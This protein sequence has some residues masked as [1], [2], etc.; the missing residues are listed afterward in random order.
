MAIRLLRLMMTSLS[1]NKDY[2]LVHH[3]EHPDAWA[4]RFESGDFVE[5]TIVFGAIAYNDKEE[6]L[7]FDFQIVD[8]PDENLSVEN[9]GLQNFA[10]MVLL[11]IIDKGLEEGF[12]KAY[13]RENG[14]ELTN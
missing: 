6:A 7:T 10:G 3:E 11:D 13:D 14:D 8:T 12:V 2:K 4:V 9:N 1:E 5:T